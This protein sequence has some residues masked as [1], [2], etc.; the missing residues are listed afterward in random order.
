MRTGSRKMRGKLASVFHSRRKNSRL[1]TNTSG[2]NSLP[3]RFDERSGITN[4]RRPISG[5]AASANTSTTICPRKFA[6]TASSRV[7]SCV[8]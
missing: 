7:Y 4:E 1:P 3:C 8:Q 6:A 2:R 5:A